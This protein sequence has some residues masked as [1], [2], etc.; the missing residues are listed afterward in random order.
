VWRVR[1]AERESGEYGGDECVPNKLE[2]EE[3]KEGVW[4]NAYGK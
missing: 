2:K 4:K 1:R 3:R